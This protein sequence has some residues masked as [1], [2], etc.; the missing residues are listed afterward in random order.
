MRKPV[1][2]VIILRLNKSEKEEASS[3]RGIGKRPRFRY[4]AARVG[5]S[6]LVEL[7]YQSGEDKDKVI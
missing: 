7:F 1:S 6:E 3:T 5:H 4:G 2:K